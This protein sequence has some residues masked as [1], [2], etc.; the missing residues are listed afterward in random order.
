MI[1]H[2]KGHNIEYEIT[3]VLDSLSDLILTSH[4]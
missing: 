3:I 2:D 1:D 4:L